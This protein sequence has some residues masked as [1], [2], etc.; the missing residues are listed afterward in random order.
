MSA[1]PDLPRND[2]PRKSESTGHGFRYGMSGNHQPA[3]NYKV[4]RSSNACE[5][6]S[7][8]CL[9]IWLMVDKVKLIGWATC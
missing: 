8:L 6:A 2:L 5:V 4:E 7:N 3:D 9:V 1:G